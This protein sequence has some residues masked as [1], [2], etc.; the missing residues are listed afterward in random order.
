MKIISN[1]KAIII[2]GQ[3]G[4]GKGTQAA[5]IAEKYN[6]YNVDTG[7]LIRNVLN[8]PTRRKNPAIQKERALY[9]AGTPNTSPFV[10][11]IWKDKIRELVKDN[12]GLILSTSFILYSEAFGDKNQPGLIKILERSYG[13]NNVKFFLLEISERESLRRNKSRL[14][15]SVCKTPILGVLK[16]KLKQCPF[17]GGKLNRRADDN[18]EIIKARLEEFRK[19][20]RPIITELKRRKYKINSINGTLLPFKVFQLITRKIK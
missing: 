11:K 19:N 1:Q 4:S 16:L 18:P 9:N 5:L 2:I 15:C 13:K 12:R 7:N 14:V 17:C 8:D 20:S 6:L 10:M 3:P